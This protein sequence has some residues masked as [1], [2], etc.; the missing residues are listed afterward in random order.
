MGTEYEGILCDKV[1]QD[2][3]RC[4]SDWDGDFTVKATFDYEEI[5][6]DSD[7]AYLD[8]E[9]RHFRTDHVYCCYA[10]LSG[11]V[12]TVQY[13]EDSEFELATMGDFFQHMWFDVVYG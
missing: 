1:E 11:E 12:L 2:I 3:A 8:V 10:R 9:I 4:F 13:Y 5:T 7:E 6:E